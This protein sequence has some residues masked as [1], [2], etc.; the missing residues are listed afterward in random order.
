VPV[1]SRQ[2]PT[3]SL[4]PMTASLVSSTVMLRIIGIFAFL[5]IGLLLGGCGA[6][7]RP[8]GDISATRTQAPAGVPTKAA[9]KAYARAVNLRAAD[10]PSM[11]IS[12]SE[13]ESEGLPFGAGVNRCGG[14][15]TQEDE[16]TAR[17]SPL[18]ISRPVRERD[19]SP[20]LSLTIAPTEGIYSKVYV[21]RSEA[22]AQRAAR[23]AASPRTWACLNA[24]RLA[25]R[26]ELAGEPFVGRVEFSPLPQLA[27]LPGV[28]VYG[29][30]ESGTLPRAFG[31][32][33][34]R[35]PVYVDV[36]GFSLGASDIVLR[37]RSTPRP[38]DAVAERRLVELLLAR[39]Q[40][41]P[42]H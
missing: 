33:R 28:P 24:R 36:V 20:G 35:P 39:A 21:L 25:D 34:G 2:R 27:V 7:N 40:T 37:V 18:F 29:Y 32:G 41:Q 12:G 1:Q 8:A 3:R 38:A 15:I 14:A 11:K 13:G 6:A 23:A 19:V 4:T 22:L 26:A 42:L 5:S 16:I 30:R 17:I 10:L 31:D 9:A